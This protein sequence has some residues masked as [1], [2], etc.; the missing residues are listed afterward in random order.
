[1]ATK[2]FKHPEKQN[3]W[4][5]QEEYF[6]ILFGEEFMNSDDKGALKEYSE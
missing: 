4:I 3:E 2:W 6:N 5:S 1:M